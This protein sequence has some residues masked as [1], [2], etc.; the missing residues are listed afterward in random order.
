MAHDSFPNLTR[1]MILDIL[2]INTYCYWLLLNKVTPWGI[3]HVVIPLHLASVM[4]Y[5]VAVP[6]Y[7]P[8]LFQLV[9]HHQRVSSYCFGLQEVRLMPSKNPSSLPSK[10]M[11]TYPS[12]SPSSIPSINPTSKPSNIPTLLPST[13]HLRPNTQ[14][15]DKISHHISYH[16][17]PIIT[18]HYSS[19]SPITHHPQSA[20][21]ITSMFTCSW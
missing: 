5:L 9:M 11:S 2:C 18:H 1:S 6:E 3:M 19:S 21:V 16:R 20:T 17:R 7:A 15:K 10:V 4:E 8:T 12:Y 14:A 13:Y